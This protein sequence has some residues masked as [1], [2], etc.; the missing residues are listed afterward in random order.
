MRP[1]IPRARDAIIEGIR[2][3]VPA[4]ARPLEGAFGAGVRTGVEQAL[5]EFVAL[6]ENPGHDRSQG[7]EVY[8][9]LGRGEA[10]EG[11]TLEALLA[12]YR[13]GARIAWRQIAG[14][15]RSEGIDSES[16]ALLAESVFAYIDELSAYS[17]EGF[18]QEQARAA[19]ESDRQRRRL[20]R[21]LIGPEAPDAA[22]VETAAGEAG[23]TLPSSLSVLVWREGRPR[24][25]SRLPHGTV[26][27]PVD[28]LSCAVVPDPEGP[29]R[30]R[31]LEVALGERPA[32]LGPAVGWTQAAV[33]AQHAFAAYRLL[34]GDRLGRTGLVIAE[35]H[36][37]ELMLH[38]DE[39]I[40]DALRRRAL[41][42]LDQE[43]ARSRARLTKTL[44][45]W[46][47]HQGAVPATAAALN[48]HPQTVRYRLGRLRELFGERLD[49][50]RGRFELELAL[51]SG[52][53]G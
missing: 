17:A 27:A 33:S 53:A 12:A 30:L 15:A 13:V 2:A 43:T 39:G 21:M 48:V 32:A 3:E 26:V 46:L 24:V 37:P 8:V 5:N 42:P 7:R 11:R 47:D 18:A 41:A 34:E 4:Y 14:G 29:D 45:A 19:A 38:R 35:E 23:W 10:R 51:R 52:S 22:A 44:L 28:E 49:D 50:P 16:L 36:L 20:V 1:H 31:Q 25:A 40:A 9:A 6:V